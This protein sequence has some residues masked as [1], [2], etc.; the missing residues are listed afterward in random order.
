MICIKAPGAVRTMM[1][2][3]R[4]GDYI[5]EEL[6]ELFKQEGVD[7]AL[8]TSGIGSFDICK[9]HTITGRTLPP[10]ERYFELEGPIE[11]GSMQGSV[12]G[13]E[14]HL[15]VVVDDVAK[16]KTYVAH[17]E[18]GSRCLFRVEMG[19]IVLEGV[20]TARI[21]DPETGLTDIVEAE[22]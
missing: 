2:S 14:P 5:I 10:G 17:L 20:K 16:G 22:D 12:A 18:E 1:I 19:V 9:L 4:K 11:V 6:R 21:T 7:A 15:H 13:G 3:F 8:V